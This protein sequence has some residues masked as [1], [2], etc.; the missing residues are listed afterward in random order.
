MSS[1]LSLSLAWPPPSSSS[2]SSSSGSVRRRTLAATNRAEGSESGHSEC[3]L[4]MSTS[5]ASWLSPA[6]APKAHE[7]SKS[8]PEVFSNH[9]RRGGRELNVLIRI[10]LQSLVPEEFV[11]LPL[12]TMSCSIGATSRFFARPELHIF[13]V[14]FLNIMRYS[15]KPSCSTAPIIALFPAKQELGSAS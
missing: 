1:S 8:N 4:R 9:P 2:S 6:G 3:I 5:Y 13:T 14:N 12:K 7:A 10:A 11:A 15:S